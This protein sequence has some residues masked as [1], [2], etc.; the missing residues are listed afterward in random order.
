MEKTQR[1]N[2]EVIFDLLDEE[3]KGLLSSHNFGAR[4]LPESILNYYL[5]LQAEIE[6]F[7]ET[8]NLK[9][10]LVISEK[11]ISVSFFEFYRSL[12]FSQKLN[13][14]EKRAFDLENEFEERNSP[15][16]VFKVILKVIWTKNVF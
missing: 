2:L 8:V 11:I 3:K 16:F 6:E 12:T 13:V 10:F 1:R 4:N 7:N 14:E 9:E 5:P 15:T